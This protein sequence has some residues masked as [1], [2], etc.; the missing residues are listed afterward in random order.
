MQSI[1]IVGLGGFL[2]SV[3]R[4]GLSS[5]PIPVDFP[6]M[7]MVINFLGSFVIGLIVEMGKDEAAISYNTI[8]FL[9]IGLCG[10]FTTF[11]TFSIET[12]SLLQNNKYLIASSYVMLSVV[13]CLF[14][15]ILGIFLARIIK[16]KLVV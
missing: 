7:T 2:G 15:T 5:I 8:L 4:Y 3:L 1:L 11:S 14:G 10:G 12:V 9:Q 16:A 6:L 13:L